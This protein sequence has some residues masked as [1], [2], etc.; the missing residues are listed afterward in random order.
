MGGVRDFYSNRKHKHLAGVFM[1]T[2]L[3]QGASCIHYS[4]LM[5]MYVVTGIEEVAAC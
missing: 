5:D 4:A 1:G 3:K 2:L